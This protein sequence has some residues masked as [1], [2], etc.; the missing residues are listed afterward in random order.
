MTSA[1]ATQSRSRGSIISSP[2]SSK[3][4]PLLS[5][6]LP[7]YNHGH[8]VREA[9]DAILTQSFGTIEVIV[10]DDA[11]TD[12]S[13]D[14]IEQFVRRDPRV[15]LLCNVE[16]RGAVFSLQRALEDATGDYVYFGAS[17]DQVLPGFFEKSMRL[18]AQYPQAGLCCSDPAYLDDAT[19]VAYA[20]RRGW[21]DRPRYFS[22]DEL[23]LVIKGE[24]I[25]GHASIVKRELLLEAGGFIPELKWHCDWF[26]LHVIAFRYGICYIPEPLAA[27]RVHAGSYSTSGVRDWSQQSQVLDHLLR[28]LKSPAYRDVLPYFVQGAVMHNFGDGIVWTVMGNPEHWDVETLMLIQGP[29]WRWNQRIVQS[30]EATHTK[31]LEEKASAIFAR[32][33]AAME[34]GR[35]DEAFSLFTELVREF[36]NLGRGW[37][38]L[39]SVAIAMGRYQSAREA[40]T[41]AIQ[42]IPNDPELY[43]KLGVSYYRDGHPDAAESAFRRTLALDPTNLN[44]HMSLAEI[45]RARGR[46]DEARRCY[47]EALEHHPD[48]VELWVRL[49]RLAVLEASASAT[50]RAAFRRLLSVDATREDVQQA[51]KTLKWPIKGWASNTKRRRFIASLRPSDV[52]IIAYPKSGIHWGRFFLTPIL[53]QRIPELCDL[54]LTWAKAGQCVPD[55]HDL[56]YANQPLSP[57]LHRPEPRIFTMHAPYDPE[58]PKVIYLVRDP[59]DVMVSFYYHHRR[60]DPEFN[61]SLDEFV[62]ENKTWAGDWGDHVAGWL[63]HA[64]GERVLVVR[65]EDLYRDQYVEQRDYPWFRRILDFCGLNADEAELKGALEVCSF[66]NMRQIESLVDKEHPDTK[67]GWGGDKSIPF[68]RRG[69]VGSWREE[70]SPELVQILNERYAEFMSLLGYMDE[71]PG[72]SEG[73]K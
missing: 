39:G 28:L 4:G 10:V 35:L 64:D 32:G 37:D 15:R 21:S 52:F 36:P 54:P 20:H 26:A 9:L 57:Y 30:L 33:R 14:L 17:D 59:R 31:S 29:L 6:L 3:Q 7:N 51:L 43:N 68:M 62:I 27:M 71:D 13:I 72:W 38:A 44:A 63:V 69:K 8:H 48:N 58:L 70:L 47:Q 16:N 11:S 19:G 18:L 55:V 60:T 23:A 41:R 22:P 5:V 50:T 65:Y 56:Y 61:M 40:L 49:S 24:H 66:Q 53:A 25:P 34:Q 73:W 12:N 1:F 2:V 46:Y 45:T 67:I 42:L